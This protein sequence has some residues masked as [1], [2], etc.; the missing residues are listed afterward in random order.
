MEKD[1][2][3]MSLEEIMGMD[4]QEREKRRTTSKTIKNEVMRRQDYKCYRCGNT[5]PARKHFHHKTPVSEGGD[6][7]LDNIMVVCSNCHDE[8]HHQMQLRKQKE[9]PS[10]EEKSVWD[11][12]LDEYLDNL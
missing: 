1:V 11:M 6:N 2:W 7:L 4:K 8:I 3:D 5:L 9:K 10:K 12:D